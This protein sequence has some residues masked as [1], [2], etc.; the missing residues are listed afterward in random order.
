MKSVALSFTPLIALVP[1]VLAV[2][3]P[4]QR[5]GRNFA[6]STVC[7]AGLTC[8]WYDDFYSQCI[9]NPTTSWP[10]SSISTT[11]RSSSTFQPLPRPRAP[12]RALEPR[13]HP[14]RA[15][16]RRR[17]PLRRV[18]QLG[19]LQSWDESLNSY[20]SLLVSSAQFCFVDSIG[21]IQ[22]WLVTCIGKLPERPVAL[23]KTT[24]MG[25]ALSFHFQEVKSRS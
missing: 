15:L 21:S 1:Y 6:G 8:V 24:V 3:E 2:P 12:Q 5:S 22:V 23:A 13:Q 16:Q 9:K 17:R 20:Q 19:S 11:K 25:S 4:G 10:N 18:P 14:A 7:D